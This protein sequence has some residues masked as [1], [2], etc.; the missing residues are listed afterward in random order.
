QNRVK[1]E[2]NIDIQKEDA[3]KE[4]EKEINTYV[5][6]EQDNNDKTQPIEETDVKRGRERPRK[7]PV[8]DTQEPVKKK[9]G[10]TK[11]KIEENNIKIEDIEEL[12]KQKAEVDA[13][14]KIDED[15]LMPG[16][17]EIDEVA[18]SNN[19]EEHQNA[20]SMEE[21]TMP[22]VDE[23]TEEFEDVSMPTFDSIIDSSENVA[24]PGIS[25]NQNLQNNSG[26]LPYNEKTVQSRYDIESRIDNVARPIEQET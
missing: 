5:Q 15:I 18:G 4:I 12:Q 26:V 3:L 7:T 11:K 6:R 16:F 23:E 21:I 20:S 1:R 22:G 9:R 8:Q 14:D 13:Q 25:S 10:R 19:V 17:D 24:M 2:Q